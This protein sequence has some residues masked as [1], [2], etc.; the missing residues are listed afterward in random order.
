VAE[1]EAGDPVGHGGGG[2][3]E[4][5]VGAD[6]TAEGEAAGV[7]DGEV[8]VGSE[9]HVAEVAAGEHGFAVDAEA[10]VAVRAIQDEDA[11]GD[12]GGGVRGR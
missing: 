7:P 5:G 10:A 9:A 11:V 2:L 8:E 6:D 1:E 3:E 4:A 12:V